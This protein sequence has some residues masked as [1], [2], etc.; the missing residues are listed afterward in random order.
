MSISALLANSSQPL[1]LAN[2]AEHVAT[3]SPIPIID[4]LRPGLGHEDLTTSQSLRLIGIQLAHKASEQVRHGTTGTPRTGYLR[5]PEASPK[6]KRRINPTDVSFN[7]T[8]VSKVV[9][10]HTSTSLPPGTL[11]ASG[12]HSI[13]WIADYNVVKRWLKEYGCRSE[14]ATPEIFRLGILRFVTSVMTDGR[15]ATVQPRISELPNFTGT[16]TEFPEGTKDVRI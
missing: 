14:G 5:I 12:K 11:V 16:L 2:F 3:K 9:F 10:T 4:P 15:Q 8:D 13:L 1:A 6:K 7:P